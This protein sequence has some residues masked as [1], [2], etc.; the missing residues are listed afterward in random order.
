MK[1]C[2]FCGK[3]KMKKEAVDWIIFDMLTIDDPALLPFI[4]N[5][6]INLI[7]PAQIADAD[8]MKFSSGLGAAL[9]CVKHSQDADFDILKQPVYQ[10]LDYKTAALVKEISSM[11]IE[12]GEYG[13][14]GRINMCKAYE[15]SQNKAKAEGIAIGEEK[16]EMNKAREIALNLKAM[17]MTEENIAKAVNVSIALIRQWFGVATAQ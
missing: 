14:E 17:G 12:L 11:D 5:Y 10:R 6:K 9:L 4:Q 15:N 3:M 16:G 7:A 8:F 13:E 2:V 1:N